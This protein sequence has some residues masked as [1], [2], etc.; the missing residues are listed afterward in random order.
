V[1]RKRRW[2]QRYGAAFHTVAFDDR[3]G[4]KYSGHRLYFRHGV[5]SCTLAHLEKVADF[6]GI[7]ARIG[8]E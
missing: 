5:G 8:G 4:K 3:R 6:D 1:R 2:E 7:L